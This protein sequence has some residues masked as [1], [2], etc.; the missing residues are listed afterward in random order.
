[1]CKLCIRFIFTSLL[2]LKLVLGVASEFR[3]LSIADA[4]LFIKP[5]MICSVGLGS[6][7][8]SRAYYERDMLSSFSLM[9]YTRI[10]SQCCTESPRFFEGLYM[11][12]YCGCQLSAQL[13][14]MPAFSDLQGLYM[15]K[16]CGCQLSQTCCILLFVA[17][18]DRNEIH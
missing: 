3:T 5:N 16:Y 1:M 6:S 18:S 7:T 13:L 10:P 2:T 17:Q 8:V 4:R 15:L 11:L 12:N 14:W 9:M